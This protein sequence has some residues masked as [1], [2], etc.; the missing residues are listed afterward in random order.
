MKAKRASGVRPAEAKGP[1]AERSV[2]LQKH[3]QA[4]SICAHPDREDI[5]R[6]FVDWKS[7]STIVRQYG[8]K[9][10]RKV[11]RHAHAFALYAKRQRNVRS[12]LEKII[13]K[14]GDVDVNAAAVVAAIQAY[15]KIN[16]QGHWV[17]R[18]EILNL[19][20]LFDR[21]S[22]EELEA[23]AR[24]GKLPDWFTE[25]AGLARHTEEGNANI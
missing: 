15:S 9:D 11:Y 1:T 3:R 23:Y 22:A 5:E 4:C 18:S 19:N 13:E 24:D 20:D 7:V 8:I 25:T 12:A 21:M 6:D 14:A 17:E 2:D 10:P 16:A